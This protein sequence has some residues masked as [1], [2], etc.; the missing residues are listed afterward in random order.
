MDEPYF[1]SYLLP[2][3]KQAIVDT[4]DKR[5]IELQEF[6][7]TEILEVNYSHGNTNIPEI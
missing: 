3:D 5:I 1:S 2:S 6:L 4:F 7:V